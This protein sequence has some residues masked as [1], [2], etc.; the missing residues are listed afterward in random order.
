M[1]ECPKCNAELE[2]EDINDED[3]YGNVHVDKGYGHCPKCK[4]K[5]WI[6][7]IYNFSHYEIEEMEED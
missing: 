1:C 5:Y 2:L 4:T 3:N 6:D 7:A